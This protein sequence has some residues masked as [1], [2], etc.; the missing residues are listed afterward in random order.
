M[1]ISK[2]NKCQ[3][4]LKHTS[5]SIYL[6]ICKSPKPFTREIRPLVEIVEFIKRFQTA[7]LT[8]ENKHPAI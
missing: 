3:K 4:R 5:Q 7:L 1:Y 6:R 8:S 2:L